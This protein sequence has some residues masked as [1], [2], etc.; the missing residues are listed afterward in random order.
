MELKLYEIADQYRDAL[1]HLADLD[2]PAEVVEHTLEGLT[3]DFAL[4]AVN[5]AAM[6]LHLEGEAELIDKA[7]QRMT[8]RRKALA[9]RADALR[10]YLKAQMERTGIEEVKSPELLLKIKL[11]PPRVILDEEALIP[12][13]FKQVERVVHIDKNGIRAALLAGR[14]V[15][16]V[17]L[18][19]GTRLDIG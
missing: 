1:N 14:T 16:G 17:H 15:K 18:E 8:K 3:G 6:V 7:I 2:L 10:D 11:N 12:R 19:Q 5:V 9:A 13:Q 4:K